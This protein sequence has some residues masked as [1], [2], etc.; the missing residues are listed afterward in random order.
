M[1]YELSSQEILEPVFPNIENLAS[2]I[3]KQILDLNGEA[4]QAVMLV[5]G[6]SLTPHLSECVAEAL[7][8]PHNRVAVRRPDGIIDLPDELHSPDAVT[9][10]GILK[11]ASLN[12]LHFLS[13]HVNNEEYSLFNF[14]ELTVS[15]ALLNAGINMRKNI[16]AIRGWV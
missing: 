5:G 9:P 15:D 4:P 3:A 2:A 11:I 7:G 10:L 13:V 6:G 12:T 16:M 1:E 8:M 14:R